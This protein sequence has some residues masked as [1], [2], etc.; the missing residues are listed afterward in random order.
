MGLSSLRTEKAEFSLKLG[1]AG[2]SA[3]RPATYKFSFM[4]PSGQRI[5][6]LDLGRR[7]IGRAVS[8]PLG[9]TAQGLPTLPRR[10]LAS[11]LAALA[12][13]A[14]EYSIGLWLLGLPLLPSGEAGS[15]AA[16]IRAFGAKLAAA[17]ALPVDYWDE[18][19]T[20]AMAEQVLRES[21]A[22]LQKRRQAVDRLA[23]VLILQSY[24]DRQS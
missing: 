22:S 10:N 5:L 9:I 15:Q 23:A 6:A 11:D 14:R 3:P 4:N 7:R 13:D 19:F 17:T 16:E 12:R 20:T 24:L 8:D 1:A 2:A 18:R 21:G